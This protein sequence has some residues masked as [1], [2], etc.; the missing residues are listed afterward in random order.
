MP[1]SAISFGRTSKSVLFS[2]YSVKHLHA[3]PHG[4]ESLPFAEGHD[5]SREDDMNRAS[6]ERLGP[7]TS[8]NES[9]L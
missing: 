9:M 7:G 6:G 8:A 2:P 4:L 5:A 1:F 3:N